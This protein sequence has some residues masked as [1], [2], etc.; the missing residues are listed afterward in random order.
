MSISDGDIDP[1]SDAD[2]AIGRALEAANLRAGDSLGG[3]TSLV[4]QGWEPSAAEA[5]EADAAFDGD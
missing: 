3:S 4:V 1:G 2:I 5:G